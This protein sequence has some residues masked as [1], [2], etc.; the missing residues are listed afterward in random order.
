MPGI[1]LGPG[2]EKVR[3]ARSLPPRS[4]ESSGKGKW[5]PI[6]AIQ[7]DHA[8]TVTVQQANA[9]RGKSTEG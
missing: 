6:K 7:R 1:L 2:G 5:Q 8:V 9:S 4:C 3:R